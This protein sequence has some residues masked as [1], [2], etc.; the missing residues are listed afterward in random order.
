MPRPVGQAA[1]LLRTGNATWSSELDWAKRATGSRTWRGS[2]TRPAASCR[3]ASATG[4]TSSRARCS[5]RQPC[6]IVYL[7]EQDRLAARGGRGPAN[8]FPP[9][10]SPEIVSKLGNRTRADMQSYGRTATGTAAAADEWSSLPGRGQRGVVSTRAGRPVGGGAV[11]GEGVP[12]DGAPVY[13]E[14]PALP[15]WRARPGRRPVLPRPGRRRR[16]TTP[17]GSGTWLYRTEGLGVHALYRATPFRSGQCG[18][19][20]STS[21]ASRPPHAGL[22]TFFVTN[23]QRRHVATSGRPTAAGR[24]RIFATSATPRPGVGSIEEPSGALKLQDVD[25]RPGALLRL[26]SC[27]TQERQQVLT[28]C[29]T[30]PRR[31]RRSVGLRRCKACRRPSRSTPRT[32]AGPAMGRPGTRPRDLQARPGDHVP[33]AGRAPCGGRLPGEWQAVSASIGDDQSI[34]SAWGTTYRTLYVCYEVPTVTGR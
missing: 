26:N 12:A 3:S 29:G 14:K 8:G 25:A 15:S 33:P 22:G 28:S 32:S 9:L 11:R 23:L 1:P 27:R 20:S 16:G 19:P 18:S 13:E 17:R 6:G 34:R 30:Q 7:H 5:A 2:A 10:R 4:P 21:W 24:P 31:V